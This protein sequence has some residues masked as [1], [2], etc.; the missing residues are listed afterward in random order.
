MRAALSR[1]YEE[2]RKAGLPAGAERFPALV[3][4]Y[5]SNVSGYEP[6]EFLR[7]LLPS[8]VGEVLVVGVGGGRDAYWLTRGG[9]RVTSIDIA[10]Q[11]GIP[12]LVL[13]DMATLP[14]RAASFDAVVVADA[15]EHTFSDREALLEFHR[16]LRP[17]GVVLLN[18]PYGD[19]AGEHHV[20]VYTEATLRRLLESAGFRIDLQVY[21]GLMPLVEQNVPAFMALFHGANLVAHILLRR[22]FYRA[23]LERMCDFDWRRGDRP[24]LRRLSRVHG[25]YIRAVPVVQR[26]D[27]R[28]VN[29]QRY[30]GQILQ[31]AASHL[32]RSAGASP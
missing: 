18:V 30:E 10:V 8:D 32:R 27:F 15:L 11:P 31:I 29:R 21:R 12:R 20:R 26:R 19:D 23:A 1:R 28:E 5:F 4:R 6:A 17:D 3:Q 24:G 22:T 9:F 14:F 16:V 7:R 13:A 2:A 25:A